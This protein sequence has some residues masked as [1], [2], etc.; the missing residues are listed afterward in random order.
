LTKFAVRFGCSW[1]G[2]NC[3]RSTYLL[4]SGILMALFCLY[5]QPI[6]GG[7]LQQV[8]FKIGHSQRQKKTSSKRGLF[9]EHEI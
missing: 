8:Y 6:G 1:L 4:V 5:W 3:E 2:T 9:V 7:F